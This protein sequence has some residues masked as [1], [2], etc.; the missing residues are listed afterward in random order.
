MSWFNIALTVSARSISELCTADTTRT[1]SINLLG[2]VRGSVLWLL[3]P[4]L[5]VIRADTAS[6]F[7][8]YTVFWG[9]LLQTY[10]Q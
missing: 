3:L 5:A 4:V 2:F 10:R 7:F 1:P 6:F 9:S 8:F